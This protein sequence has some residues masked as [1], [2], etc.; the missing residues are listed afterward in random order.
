MESLP[1]D[2]LGSGH[3]YAGAGSLEGSYSVRNRLRVAADDV[4]CL[5]P[6]GA[7][8][9]IEFDCVTFIQRAISILLNYREVHEDVFAGGALDKA[10]TF[11]SV[12]PLD[13]TFLSV[14][15]NSFSSGSNVLS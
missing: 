13:C 12:E 9:Q 8:Q 5:Q 14:H 3:V 10:V 7:S 15:A 1:A 4:C 6:F 2:S 11:S